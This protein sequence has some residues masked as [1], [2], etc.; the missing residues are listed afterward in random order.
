LKL[1]SNA[2]N[3]RTFLKR[4]ALLAGGVAAFPHVRLAAAN[5]PN[6]AINV[7]IIGLG[8]KG[9]QQVQLFSSTSGV[10][11]AALCETDPARLDPEV[12]KLKQK[13]VTVFGATDP[14][15]I[16]ERKDMDAVVIATPNHWH[17]LLTVWAIRAGKDVYVEKP[18]SHNVWEGQRMVDEAARAGRIVQSGTQYRSCTGVRAA[19]EW[20]RE[21]HLG[22][23]QWVHIVWFEFRP[24]IGKVAPYRPADVD[25]DLWCGP[26]PDEPLT[27]PRLHYDWHWVWSTGNGDMGNST[28]HPYDAARMF[29]PERSWPTRVVS[30]GER[31]IYDDAG[32]TPNMQYTLVEYPGLPVIIEHRNLPM[33][34]EGLAGGKGDAAMDQFRRIREGMVLQYEGGYFAGL[35]GGGVVF[36]HK[37]AVVKRFEG[38]GGGTHAQNFLDAMRSRKAEDLRAPIAG[39]HL[40]S[41]VCHLGNISYRMGQHAP[42]RDCRAALGSA[43]AVTDGFERM[44]N[45]LKGLDVDLDKTPFKLGAAL[46]IDPTSG[47]ILKCGDGHAQQLEQARCL[48]RGTYRAPYLMPT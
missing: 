43:T 1:K 28:I 6:E 16:L 12:A 2:H 20:L 18:V 26:A 32:Q 45:A 44:V 7:A 46:E 11:I 42:L 30:L 23:L 5:S 14:R 10:R 17:A 41:A 19:A 27:R 34:K 33:D 40:S 15:R 3:R 36:D 48:A 21:G 13:G 25:Y 4:S 31:F 38:E 37:D 47:N 29:F 9:R 22:K 35:R 8:N 24:A 39:G